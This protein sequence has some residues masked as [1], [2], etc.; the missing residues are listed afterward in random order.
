MATPE[1][2]SSL[3]LILRHFATA[4]A[5]LGKLERHLQRL[6]KLI[7]EGICF[8]SYPEYDDACRGYSALLAGLPKIDGW[9]PS[10]TPLDLDSIA[11]QRFDA[12]EVG[13]PEM[14][15]SLAFERLIYAL[16]SSSDSCENVEWL[17]KTNAPDRGRDLSAYRVLRD[18]LSGVT[19]SRVIIQCKHWLDK[20][21]NLP[22]VSSVKGQMALWET[23]RVDILI[24]AT[25]GRFTTDAIDFIEKH[26][27]SDRAMRIE[28]WPESHLERL[29]AE[30]PGLVAEFRLR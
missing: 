1:I 24:I 18:Q 30:R 16:I 12:E 26:N 13:E 15:I 28:M 5:K 23:P 17:T 9:S 2:E 27:A 6:I 8:G 4:E 11:R 22:D 25:T 21:V 7:P 3:D 14:L 19:R 29:L 20:S 10:A